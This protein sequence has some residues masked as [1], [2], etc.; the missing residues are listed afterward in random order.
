[1]LFSSRA[2]VFWQNAKLG[3]STKIARGRARG[4]PVIP[5][6]VSEFRLGAENPAASAMGLGCDIR[7]PQGLEN[8]GFDVVRGGGYSFFSRR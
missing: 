5:R 6:Y 1:M 7:P 4:D 3:R 8:I 2:Y